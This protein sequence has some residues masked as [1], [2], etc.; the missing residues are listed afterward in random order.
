[1]LKP[2]EPAMQPGNG[3]ARPGDDRPVSELVHQLVEQGKAYAQAEIDLGKAI[4][5]SKAQAFKV[6][7]ILLATAFLFAQAAFCV[8][9]VA[10]FL[11][12][13][14]LM[15]PLLAGFAAFLIFA[16]LGGGLAYAAVQ[17]IGAAQ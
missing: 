7:A 9:G 4:A 1:M 2:A 12:L 15:G 13:L 8:L 10:L 6:P 16:G 14:P 17:K 11:A 5:T 3:D